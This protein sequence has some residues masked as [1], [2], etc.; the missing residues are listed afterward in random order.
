[1]QSAVLQRWREDFIIRE[2]NVY[3]LDC[4]ILT[5]KEVL[6]A[7]GHTAKFC[8]KMITSKAGDEHVRA[9]HI[10]EDWI[11][12]RLEEPNVDPAV[13]KELNDVLARIDDLSLEELHDALRKYF[14]PRAAPG[15]AAAAGKKDKK[16]ADAAAAAATT[17]A[18]RAPVYEDE[19]QAP[20]DFNLMFGTGIGPSGNQPGFLRPETAQGMFVNFRRLLDYAGG[21]LPFGAAQIGKAFRNEINPQQGLLR[22][23]EFWLAEVEFFVHPQRSEHARF[24]RIADVELRLFGRDRQLGDRKLDV[25]TVREA[26]SR[27]LIRSQTLA[28]FMART[29]LFLKSVGCNPQYMRMRQHLPNEMAH[30]ARDCWD[31]ELLTT[32]GWI[33]VVGHADRAAYDLNAH[34]T[35]SGVKLEVFEQW[36]QANWKEEEVVKPTLNKSAIGKALKQQAQVVISALETLGKSE[37]M[38]LE[39]KLAESGKA[40]FKDVE[41]TRD[42]AKF[43]LEKVAVKGE[44]VQPAVIEPAFGIGRIMYCVFEHSFRQ[45]VVE[46]ETEKRNYLS[47]PV[48]V[49]PVKFS[50]LP[51]KASDDAHIAVC[52]RIETLL[53]AAGVSC[54]VDAINETIGRRYA[55]TD[56]IGIPFGITVDDDT[57]NKTHADYESVTLRDRDSMEQVRVKLA[58]DSSLAVVIEAIIKN[59]MAWSDVVQRFNLPKF[60][61]N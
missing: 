56:E 58:G 50:V 13:A 35:A 45:R 27:G 20:K 44:I 10:L 4:T 12:K 41:L 59:R 36:Q 16:K 39:A 37:A 11:E 49:A 9:D 43:A 22:V 14:V 54:K 53:V 52:E 31:A 57:V 60:V 42:M 18:V 2:Q 24:D 34:Q 8:D 30:Y 28:Y 48:A 51:L 61:A 17:A 3:E 47:L 23:R 46:K 55:R 15:G 7:S 29:W 32:Y 5:A 33:E 25:V 1:M 26:V 40:T 21:K 19:W 38:A 6:D